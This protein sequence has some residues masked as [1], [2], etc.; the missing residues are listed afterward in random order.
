MLPDERHAILRCITGLARNLRYC[1]YARIQPWM[2]NNVFVK[3]MHAN[4]KK[5]LKWFILNKED[6]NYKPWNYHTIRVDKRTFGYWFSLSSVPIFSISVPLMR[7]LT[8]LVFFLSGRLA[9]NLNN[10]EFLPIFLSFPT[11]MLLFLEWRAAVKLLL[12][13]KFILICI[14]KRMTYT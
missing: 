4:L 1:S 12:L 5:M 8:K 10:S 13:I 6:F 9:I 3:R 14:A 11:K 2:N 7:Y